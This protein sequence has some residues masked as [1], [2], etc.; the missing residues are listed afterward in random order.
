MQHGV[1]ARYW[2][3]H[4]VETLFRRLAAHQCNYLRLLTTDVL[5]DPYFTE[6]RYDEEMVRRMDLIMTLAEEYGIAVNI[7]IFCPHHY[8]S[9]CW[10]D[11]LVNWKKNP[12]NADNGGPIAYTPEPG[13][14]P[15]SVE[16]ANRRQRL[17]YDP[18]N[19]KSMEAQKARIRWF[20]E[21]YTGRRSVFC[22]GLSNDFPYALE[23][24]VRDWLT[25]MAAFTRS[26]DPSH[27]LVG[28]HTFSGAE[29]PAWLVDAVD[30]TCIRAYP[31]S[32]FSDE[33]L[34]PSG[35][36][37][38]NAVNVAFW[39]RKKA[40]EHLAYAKPVINGEYGAMARS[41][42]S[43]TQPGYRPG[44]RVTPDMDRCSL[45]GLWSSLA[46][47]ASAG[48]RWTGWDGFFPLTDEAWKQYDAVGRFCK[49]ID[50]ARF[51][52]RP[53]DEEVRIDEA[54]LFRCA[55][56]DDRTLLAW[57]ASADAEGKTEV[58]PSA[59]L[60][61]A[62]PAGRYAMSWID[63]ETNATLSRTVVHE[64]PKVTSSPVPTRNAHVLL[65]ERMRG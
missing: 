11:R 28:I 20:V 16:E 63:C 13:A 9:W 15:S 35:A 62:F 26:I 1:E 7:E 5:E 27:H 4:E 65:I 12:Y 41:G 59:E 31:W 55:I 40:H 14:D 61:G 3:D 8:T 46:A 49:R 54:T 48:H 36:Q 33:D 2:P 43:M 6:G 24:E 25:E 17:A 45:Y 39:L 64:L 60:T 53:C 42:D 37:K 29:W 19:Q 18:S 56:R 57:I 47:G 44:Y 23:P 10:P 30:F 34:H 52:S 51:D 38:N 32:H 50:W 22:W 21:R 58:T